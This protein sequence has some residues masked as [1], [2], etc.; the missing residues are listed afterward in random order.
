MK[1]DTGLVI[2]ELLGFSIHK[3]VASLYYYDYG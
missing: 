2:L 3:L 1:G